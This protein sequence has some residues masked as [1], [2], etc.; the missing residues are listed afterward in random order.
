M[1]PNGWPLCLFV[2]ILKYGDIGISIISRCVKDGLRAA[3]KTPPLTRAPFVCLLN[4]TTK[5]EPL[6]QELLRPC[7]AL[8]LY[9]LLYLFHV[10]IKS[11]CPCY[12]AFTINQRND[13]LNLLKSKYKTVRTLP[14]ITWAK[15][16]EII[17]SWICHAH[18]FTYTV[19]KEVHVIVWSVM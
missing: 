11:T 7:R 2:Q 1:Q 12:T 18:R 19:W 5:V 13:Q 4:T 14:K 9:A 17:T 6:F 3:I 15:M 10:P 8:H 16:K